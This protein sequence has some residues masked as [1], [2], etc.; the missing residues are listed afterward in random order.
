MIHQRCAA[1]VVKTPTTLPIRDPMV[2]AVNL[3]IF[4]TLKACGTVGKQRRVTC[5]DLHLNPGKFIL[6]GAG[7]TIGNII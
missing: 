4:L 3:L 6:A 2:T 7:E 1:Q 5:A